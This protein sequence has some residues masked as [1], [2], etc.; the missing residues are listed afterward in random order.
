MKT[1]GGSL[2]D[3]HLGAVDRLGPPLGADGEHVLL[4]GQLDRL[5][6]DAGQVEV[7]VEG[8]ALAVGVHRHG[9]RPG[10][11]PEELLGEPVEVAERVGA[12]KHL[13]PPNQW[14]LSELTLVHVYNT[15][16]GYLTRLDSD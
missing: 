9:R 12:H 7:D 10:G 3:D 4:D 14:S 6:A 13:E 15:R 8:V 11:C 2:G 5:G 16:G 1:P